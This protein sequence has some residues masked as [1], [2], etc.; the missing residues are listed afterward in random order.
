MVKQKSDI[1]IPVDFKIYCL[2]S[3]DYAK[4][5]QSVI[6]GKIHLLHV[7][8]SQ[9]WWEGFFRINELI[10]GAKEKLTLLKKEQELPE[11]TELMVITGKRYLEI[12]KYANSISARYIIMSDNYPLSKNTKILGS[13]ISQVIMKAEQ[14]VISITENEDSIFKNLVVPLDLNQ[15]CRLQLYNSVAIALT[16]QSKIHLV[17]VLFSPDKLQSSRIHEK[18]E[19]YKKMY[20]DNG[21]DYTAELL[22]KEEYLAYKEIIKYCKLN[23]VD[24]VLIMTHKES[25]KFDNYLGAFAQHIINEAT[26]PVVTINNASAQYWERELRKPSDPLGFIK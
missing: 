22:V 17:S 5:L 4:K 3:I 10:Q 23:K 7:I 19:K 8:E 1:L 18:I 25:Y 26:M 6:K 14:P 15:S 24:S 16:H 12:A 11:D 21:I 20:D 9:S 2:K 13:T